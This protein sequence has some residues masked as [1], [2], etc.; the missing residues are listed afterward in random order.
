MKKIHLLFI[1]LLTNYV[2]SQIGINTNLTNASLN[3]KEGN[4][5]NTTDT[6]MLRAKN[7]LGEDLF[8]IKNNGN[9]TLY[10]SFKTKNNPG[11]DGQILVSNGIN[12]TPYWTSSVRRGLIIQ[13][14]N[15]IQKE[16]QSPYNVI[17]AGTSQIFTN[18]IVL[19]DVEASIAKWNTNNNQLE[20]LEK[21]IYDISIGGNAYRTSDEAP[22]SMTISILNS[23]GHQIGRSSGLK[24]VKPIEDKTVNDIVY[25]YLIYS[26][27][28]ISLL[29][30]PGDVVYAYY[31]TG[32]ASDIRCIL[33]ESFFNVTYTELPP[34][35]EN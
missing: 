17:S 33:N 2:F 4:L 13:V 15:A 23:S 3:I 30:S 26:G 16:P 18:P 28:S 14:Y 32:G 8:Q 19:S 22:F 7:N 6:L 11:V 24:N 5:T 25:K 21:G 20:I 29:L 10:N 27:A 12:K 9:M 35:Y 1:L 34:L 31:S